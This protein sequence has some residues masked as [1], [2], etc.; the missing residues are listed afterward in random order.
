M[1]FVEA[2]AVLVAGVLA[3]GVVDRLGLEAPLGQAGVDG[4]F[5][6]ALDQAENGRLL[7]GLGAAPPGP[8]QSAAARWPHDLH[9]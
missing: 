1:D 9:S 2:V 3:L 7:A 4:L 6:G 8:L 5:A